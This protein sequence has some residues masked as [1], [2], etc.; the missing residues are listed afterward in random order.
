MKSNAIRNA[1]RGEECTFQIAG[2]CN[3]SNETTVFCH[4][5]SEFG[6]IGMKQTDISGAFGCSSCHDA[7]DRRAISD[8]YE[9]HKF[10]YNLRALVR[11]YMR[12]WDKGVITIKGAK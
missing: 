2:V 6:G 5:P 8:E 3:Y 10:F 7:V 9:D 11:T 4:L 12:L 1:A